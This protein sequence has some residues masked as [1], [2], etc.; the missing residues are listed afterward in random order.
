MLNLIKRQQ[1]V[2]AKSL[3]ILVSSCLIGHSVYALEVTSG[4]FIQ[5]NNP[6]ALAVGTTFVV[7]DFFDDLALSTRLRNDLNSDIVLGPGPLDITQFYYS[8]HGT[9]F[10]DNPMRVPGINS[11]PSQFEFSEGGV[12]DS[13]SRSRIGLGGV[14][15]FDL[16][17]RED[18]TPRYFMLGDWTLEYDAVRKQ[19][20]NFS[21][22]VNKLVQPA[23]Y[24]VSG[25]FLRNHIDFPT[26][27]FDV[28]SS[29]IFSNTDSFYL[30]G[31]LGWSPEIV[32]AFFPEEVLY[33]ATARFV[34][35]AQDDVAF[36]ES[37]VAKIPCVFP[38]I[39]ANGQAG[40]IKISAPEQIELAIDLGIA[41][42]DKNIKAD[43][44]AAFVYQKIWY[45]L[46][47]EFKWTTT[48]SAA[49]QGSL[50][51]FRK[52]SL[53]SPLQAINALQPGSVITVYFAVDASQNGKFDPP[54]RFSSVRLNID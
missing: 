12:L 1:K 20:Y 29:T 16:P 2:L 40:H 11:F 43:Y 41:T 46:N 50:I 37:A 7:S 15:R 3:V 45:W 19:G 48:A 17:P 54:Y 27:A 24:D 42:M 32:T 25:W 4:N 21:D 26:V 44:F 38:N 51:D 53:P 39:T 34:M 5:T 30:S 49:Y 18:G 52:I 47:K 36:A 28:L 9:D 35:C 14:M 33:H 31:E 23:D 13:A 8:V 6:D 10:A 22:D